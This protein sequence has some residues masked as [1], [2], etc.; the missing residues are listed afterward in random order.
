MDCSPLI[1]NLLGDGRDIG[2]HGA[3]AIPASIAQQTDTAGTFEDGG[4]PAR[5][6]YSPST[7]STLDLFSKVLLP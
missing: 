7:V 3:R 5:W 4:S 6:R 1:T 2:D